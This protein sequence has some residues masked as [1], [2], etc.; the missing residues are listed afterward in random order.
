[1][2][3]TNQEYPGQLLIGTARRRELTLV[4]ILVIVFM[5]FTWRGLTM[6]FSTDD[7]MNMYN[8]WMTPALKLWK[9]QLLPWMPMSRPLGNAAY[10]VFYT[11]F[12]FQPL[13]LY[14][15]CWL[16]L[17]GNVFASWRFFRVLAPSVSIA[18][19]ALTLTLVHGLFQDLYLSAGTIYDRL[20]FLFTILAVTF[21]ARAR[22]AEDGMSARRIAMLCFL[23]LMAM[24]SK[25][26]GAVVPAILFCYECVYCLPGVLREKRVHE[27]IR[28]IAPLYCLM[29]GILAAFVIGRVRRA[30]GL[31]S[32]PNYQPHLSLDFWLKS[33]AEYLSDILYH[34]VQFSGNTAAAVLVAMLALAA[35]LRC[36]AMLFGWLFFVV[37]ITPVALISI[38]TGYVLYVPYPGLGLYCA[39]LAGLVVRFALPRARTV[40]TEEPGF[41][42]SAA[43]LTVAALMTCVH[44]AFWPNPWVV[45]DSPAW[46]LTDKM[47]NDYPTLK[48]GA[49]ILFA[50]DYAWANGYDTMFNLRLLYHDPLIEV[51]KLKGAAV[52]LP[53][54]SLTEYDHVFTT[55]LDSY[56]E[57]DRRDVEQS[58]KLNV[59]QDYLPGRHFDSNRIDH[60]AYLVSG[61]LDSGRRSAGYWTTRS[62]TLKF[63]IY[64]ADSRLKLKF[65]LPD[66]EVTGL[67]R[68]LSAFV[69]GEVVG[70]AALIHSGENNADFA[71]PAHAI[72]ASGFTILELNVNKPYRK[73]NQEYG[74][75]LSEA[76]FD[77]VGK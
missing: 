69:D 60:A 68:N 13:P 53:G 31:L 4:A 52:L 63:D 19:V 6:F 1:M 32:N 20:C 40:A 61:F 37:A 66:D 26:S 41:A 27:W 18:L 59:L 58:I 54:R 11:I 7:L 42:Q 9:A 30:D 57:L 71:V 14:V 22:Q 36:R 23:V 70:T 28:S 77:Y 65:W 49:R 43:V 74:V 33:V 39:A 48:P 21:Y 17:V 73:D 44:A 72:N 64:P 24:N 50:D 2:L 10:R 8:A 62:A 12:G 67:G 29:A 76:G 56:V 47:R 35:A 3:T 55:G 34:R 75:V 5:S 16:L 46:R 38:R 15:F 45:R 51:A 25:E